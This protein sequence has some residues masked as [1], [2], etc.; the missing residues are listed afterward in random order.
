MLR[1][2]RH[3]VTW[4]RDTNIF[5]CSNDLLISLFINILTKSN[6][7][8]Y[9][10]FSVSLSRLRLS[11][12]VKKRSPLDRVRYHP[13]LQQLPLL[14][15]VVFSSLIFSSCLGSKANKAGYTATL[16]AC[17]RAGAV[18]EKVTGAFGQ[19]QWAQNAQKRRNSKMGTVRPTDRL[20]DWPTDRP[21]DKAG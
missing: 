5:Y 6:F 15:K 7:K 20:T 9:T 16:V 11:F 8:A 17:G 3:F 4:I 2:N 10:R 19:E 12:R 21:T 1:R 18:L 13:T 14:V